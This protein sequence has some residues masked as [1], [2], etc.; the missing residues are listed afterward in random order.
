[1]KTR[2]TLHTHLGNDLENGFER[3]FTKTEDLPFVAMVGMHIGP[4]VWI[5]FEIYHTA[6]IMDEALVEIQAKQTA[7]FQE[8][9]QHI[10]GKL[11][12]SGWVELK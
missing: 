4:L 9:V 3:L 8:D 5:Q 1:M 6:Y 10:A 2:I 11:I 7:P 12:E